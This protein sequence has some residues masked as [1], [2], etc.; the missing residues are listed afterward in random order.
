MLAGP[1]EL[2]HKKNR[3]ER[4]TLCIMEG[5]DVSTRK[6]KGSKLVM[7]QNEATTGFEEAMK[8]LE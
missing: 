4:V 8:L 6:Y 2:K 7:T 3:D 5:F 1:Y